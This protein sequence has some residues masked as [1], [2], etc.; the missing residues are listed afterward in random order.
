MLTLTTDFGTRD[1]YVAALKGALQQA[2]PGTPIVD[3]THDIDPYDR[4]AGALYLYRALRSWPADAVHLCVVD[5][6][7]GSDRSWLAAQFSF[8][9]VVLPDNGLLHYLVSV[10][11]P[12]QLRSLSDA[13]PTGSTTFEARDRIAPALASLAAEGSTWVPAHSYRRLSVPVPV[14]DVYRSQGHVI[15]V[16]RYGSLVTN[17][18]RTQLPL[19]EPEAQAARVKVFIGNRL[20]GRL[21]GSY[22]DVQRGEPLA[23]FNS[24]GWLEIA[25]RE[26]NAASFYSASRGQRIELASE[27]PLRAVHAPQTT[28]LI[29]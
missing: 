8:G 27:V 2:L 5:P 26:G 13:W 12:R 10:E 15:H 16:D 20:V 4:V 17:I 6:G 24:D 14:Y 9:W 23:L 3:L 29:Q 11:Q 1:G 7:V 28:G 25:C 19:Y 22:S 21:R 18:E